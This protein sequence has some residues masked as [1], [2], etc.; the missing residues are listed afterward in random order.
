M[1]NYL[2][3][4]N[5]M[6][7][8]LA[9]SAV[10]AHPT[11]EEAAAYL[12]EYHGKTCTPAVLDGFRK[13]RPERYERVRRQLTPRLEQDLADGLLD[14]ARLAATATSLA[15][16]QTMKLLEAG[17]C[18]DPSKVARD[19]ADVQAK[20]IDKKLA[21]E[22]RPSQVIETRN[23]NEIIRRLEGMNVIKRVDA[24]TTVLEESNDTR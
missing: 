13:A 19:L 12:Q 17:R 21:L 23:T 5:D 1:S 3:Y 8:E 10:A 9:L 16:E 2:S 11:L 14:N 7:W 6:D 20:S 18:Q 4:K 24:E 15:I 22:G